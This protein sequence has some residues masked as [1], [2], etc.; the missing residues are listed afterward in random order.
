M[1]RPAH[2]DN[3]ED[4]EY[5]A[6]W[7]STIEDLNAIL[8]DER[9]PL[10]DKAQEVAKEL[11]RPIAEA[12]VSTGA[13]SA[14]VAALR[15]VAN[16]A[17]VPRIDISSITAG[18]RTFAQL[19]PEPQDLSKKPAP[20]VDDLTEQSSAVE[21]WS[22]SGDVAMELR[23]R[24][25]ESNEQ[26]LQHFRD[27]QAKQLKEEPARRARDNRMYVATW[28]AAVGGVIAALGTIA[29]IVV[30]VAR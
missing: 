5:E 30:T 21:V 8:D 13:I 22:V 3:P 17:A 1:N 26:L 27:L 29:G 24:Q 2:P 20:G 7:E 25:A 9:H 23:R 14:N 16:A 19:M 6:L 12:M 15:T 11:A 4:A 28:I 10:H 18:L